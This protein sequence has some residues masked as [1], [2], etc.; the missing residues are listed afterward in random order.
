MR[1]DGTESLGEKII[2][3]SP[4]T[5]AFPASVQRFS[6]VKLGC[7]RLDAWG[8]QRAVPSSLGKVSP[9]DLPGPDVFLEGHCQ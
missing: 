1:D 5:S 7:A 4:S 2:F 8:E 3:F 6:A 9:S